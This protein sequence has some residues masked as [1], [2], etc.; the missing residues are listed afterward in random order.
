LTVTLDSL[1][2]ALSIDYSG[3]DALLTTFLNDA[4][5]RIKSSVGTDDNMVDF[6]DNNSTFDTAVIMLA[7]ASY[8][9][10]SATTEASNR[11]QVVEYPLGVTSMI[12]K[13]K[14]SYLL[15]LSHRPPASPKGLA[16][17]DL[18]SRSVRLGWY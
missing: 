7:D 16:A 6:W 1:K 4:I 8:K 11:Q 2:A 5:D 14:G 12:W 3:H 10:R 9:N 15:E 13:L 18:T 17:T